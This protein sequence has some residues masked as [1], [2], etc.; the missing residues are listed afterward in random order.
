ML[1]IILGDASVRINCG[2][3]IILQSA[4]TFN[5]EAAVLILFVKIPKRLKLDGA[6]G[7]RLRKQFISLCFARTIFTVWNLLLGKAAKFRP[8]SNSSYAFFVFFA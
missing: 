1:K 8:I 3:E 5:A 2:F 4:W 7:S 6:Y